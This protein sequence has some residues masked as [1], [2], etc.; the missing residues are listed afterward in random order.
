MKNSE[1]KNAIILKTDRHKEND[2]RLVLL[3][4][5]G[6][7]I[8]YATGALKS[9]A[10]LKGA[11]QLFN[12]CEFTITGARVTGAHV[13][14]NNLGITREIHRFYLAG[15]ISDAVYGAIRNFD[16]DVSEIFELVIQ[17]YSYM[18]NNETSALKLFIWF[19]AYLLV[20]LGYDVE[21][22]IDSFRCDIKELDN[23]ELSL[24]NAK[25]IMREIEK[26]Y[27]QHLDL[28]LESSKLFLL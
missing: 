27:L 6:I 18:A 11:L 25:R 15:M 5:D 17:T 7:G 3:S 22:E 19:F 10:K 8:V 23:V 9:T 1:I 13:I 24:S 4:S 14:D 12:H 28:I 20:L 16:D 26:A 2:M 21:E